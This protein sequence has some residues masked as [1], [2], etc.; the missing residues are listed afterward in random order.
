MNKIGTTLMK[1][2]IF[3]K[4]SNHVHQPNTYTHTT[5]IILTISGKQTQKDENMYC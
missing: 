5:Y 3:H 4:Q 1:T 2:M